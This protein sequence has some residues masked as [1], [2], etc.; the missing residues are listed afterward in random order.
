VSRSDPRVWTVAGL[1]AALAAYVALTVPLFGIPLRGDETLWPRQAHA[2]N[3]R[4]IPKVPFGADAYVWTKDSFAGKYGAD[5]GLWHPPGY[6][7]LLAVAER[8]TSNW[9]VAGRGL[10]MLLGLAT[11]ALT[12]LLT[13]GLAARAGW[14]S[15]SSAAAATLGAIALGTAPYWVFESM[16]VDIDPG[17][18]SLAVL[19]A[20]G[21]A[22]AYAR[23]P[24]RRAAIGFIALLVALMWVK[25][26]DYPFLSFGAVGFAVLRR[27]RRLALRFVMLL[28]AGLAV[29]AATWAVYATTTGIPWDY[30]WRFS[31]F[32][33]S[34][35]RGAGALRPGSPFAIADTARIL[36]S[37]LGWPSTLVGLAGVAGLVARVFRRRIAREWDLLTLVGLPLVLFFVVFYPFPGKYVL[38]GFAPLL[39]AGAL[40]ILG[41]LG[42]AP[43][44]RGAVLA[45]ALATPVVFLFQWLVVG[46]M[47]TGPETRLASQKTFGNA[48]H[49]PRLAK[50]VLALVPLVLAALAFRYLGLRRTLA[51]CAA[52]VVVVVLPWNAAESIALHPE[53][54]EW[55]LPT[56]ET[57]FKSAIRWVHV[58]VHDGD[59]IESYWDVG[60]YMHHGRIIPT[61]QFGMSWSLVEAGNALRTRPVEYVLLSRDRFP[62]VPQFTDPLQRYFRPIKTLGDW[63]VY[64]RRTGRP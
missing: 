57:G 33:H 64:A 29:F 58:N 11:I 7:Y 8:T 38:P 28:M 42:S 52:A 16:L 49:D 62:Q 1:L 44:R 22:L 53:Q 10:A 43:I 15:R 56:R 36:V 20:S 13:R 32:G 39:A 63:V 23:L 25:P 47:I 21:G 60:Y 41:V 61:D 48:A 24:G 45:T 9:R 14:G 3:V 6:L 5:Y 40:E 31:Y 19:A 37:Q 46:D 4:G 17:A 50:Y 51:A 54:R 59:L 30:P 18:L 55:I 27:D 34:G 2:I 12:F 26:Q 35:G